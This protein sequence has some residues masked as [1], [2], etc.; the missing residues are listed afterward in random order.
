METPGALPQGLSD[1]AFVMLDP[2]V[3]ILKTEVDECSLLCQI[4]LEVGMVVP[5]GEGLLDFVRSLMGKPARVGALHEE[6]DDRELIDEILSSL[7]AHG[8]AHVTSH[9]GPLG[10]GHFDGPW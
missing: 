1:D 7:L 10:H 5:P 8:F 2:A 9:E 6:Y 3:E 4:D